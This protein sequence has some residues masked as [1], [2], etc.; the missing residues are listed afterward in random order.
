MQLDADI[1]L[2]RRRLYEW[3]LDPVFTLTGTWNR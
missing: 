2:E 3:A 1:L